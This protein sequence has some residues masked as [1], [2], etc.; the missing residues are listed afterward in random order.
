MHPDY[1]DIRDR[2][3]EQPAWYDVHGVPRYGRPPEKLIPFMRCIKCQRCGEEF[4]VCLVGEIYH[5]L[6][7]RAINIEE[8]EPCPA[9]EK[10]RHTRIILAPHM[11]TWNKETGSLDPLPLPGDWHYGDPPAHDGCIGE[12]MNSV[13]EYE[14]E[15]WEKNRG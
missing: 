5:T 7:G 12:T 2:I 1:S 10:D 8:G 6:Y 4:R 3:V 13:P 11:T 15:E 9:N 14:W